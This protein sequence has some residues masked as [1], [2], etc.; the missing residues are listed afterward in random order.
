MFNVSRFTRP[1]RPLLSTLDQSRGLSRVVYS[2]RE[3]RAALADA[4]STG[5]EAD[6]Y[7]GSVSAKV[8]WATFAIVLG[9]P[10]KLT[11]PLVIPATLFGL[12]LQGSRGAPITS[13]STG[14]VLEVR[15]EYTEIRDLS[16]WSAAGPFDFNRTADVCLYVAASKV[17]IENVE[18]FIADT[19]V[20]ID[21][22]ASLSGTTSTA[23]RIRNCWHAV[24]GSPSLLVPSG[25]TS[26]VT[27]LVVQECDFG[28]VEIRSAT[29][30]KLVSNSLGEVTFSGGQANIISRNSLTGDITYNGLRSVISDNT[31]IN[32]RTVDTS[33]GGGNNSISGN[34]SPGNTYT[35]AGTDALGL[36]T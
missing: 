16:F 17:V 3:L 30:S 12:T 14:N 7:L 13:D 21:S 35:T 22:D 8:R 27:E 19:L 15:G 6:H 31:W 34:A 24:S 20:S 5:V 36:N 11:A 23:I 2:E 1:P 10:I 26:S 29:S 18:D 32:S 9:G 25:G 28:D 4:L 33:G